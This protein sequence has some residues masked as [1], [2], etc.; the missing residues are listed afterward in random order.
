MPGGEKM[1]FTIRKVDLGLIGIAGR[2]RV[3]QLGSALSNGS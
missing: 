3:D 2:I 1:D